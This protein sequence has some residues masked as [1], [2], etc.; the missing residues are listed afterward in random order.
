MLRRILHVMLLLL[1]PIIA[2]K[3]LIPTM[4]WT[5]TSRVTQTSTHFAALIIHR[6]LLEGVRWPFGSITGVR[7]TGDPAIRGG[8]VVI[9]LIGSAS[10]S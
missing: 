7:V 6:L 9:A 2:A 8:G 10:S 3:I 1:L 5:N 4:L